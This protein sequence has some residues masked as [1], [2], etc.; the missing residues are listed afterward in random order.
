MNEKMLSY[1][2]KIKILKIYFAIK[3]LFKN[4]GRKIFE[5]SSWFLI[6]EYFAFPYFR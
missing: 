1:A 4:F 6:T 3:C 2:K 5:I